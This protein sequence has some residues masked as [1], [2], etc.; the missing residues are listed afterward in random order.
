M[1]NSPVTTDTSGTKYTEPNNHNLFMG[2]TL[3]TNFSWKELGMV[4][5]V[6]D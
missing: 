3:P 5:P 6:F 2:H 1:K 4:P